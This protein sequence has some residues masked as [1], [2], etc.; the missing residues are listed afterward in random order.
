MSARFT[1]RWRLRL[2]PVDNTHGAAARPKTKFAMTFRSEPSSLALD[3]HALWSPATR[4]DPDTWEDAYAYGNES[5]FPVRAAVS[6]SQDRGVG[7]AFWCMLLANGFVGDAET[8]PDDIARNLPIRSAVFAAEYSADGFHVEASVSAGLLG[9]TLAADGS[10]TVTAT[11]G[12]TVI[13]VSS[14]GRVKRALSTLGDD[15]TALDRLHGEAPDT[16]QFEW[17]PG[18]TIG[19]CGRGLP[20]ELLDDDEP[21]W[22]DTL[23]A[24][25][26]RIR[27]LR[28]KAGLNET[29]STFVR[30]RLPR[31][32]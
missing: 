7:V 22:D 30:I 19:L 29:S 27:T 3:I 15:L 25:Q 24:F 9:V 6:D 2:F 11:R 16:W 23:P 13:R 10:A 31:A 26:G 17:H 18:D 12:Y 1:F 14:S 32:G 21:W 20:L 5:T 28:Q 8:Y 4:L